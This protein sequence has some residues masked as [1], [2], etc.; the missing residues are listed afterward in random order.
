MAY[1]VR[2]IVHDKLYGS[3]IPDERRPFLDMGHKAQ[4]AVEDFM[5]KHLDPKA[6]TL[7][8]KYRE[9]EVRITFAGLEVVGHVDGLIYLAGNG[10]GNLFEPSYA[11][12]EVKA[13][14]DSN[15]KRLKKAGDM[16]TVYGHYA[17]QAQTYMNADYL[18]PED[19]GTFTLAGPFDYTI[20]VFVNR[21]TS[22]M[23]GGI[24][25][26]HPAWTY[27]EDM[28]LKRDPAWKARLLERLTVAKEALESKTLPEECDAPGY[29]YFCKG[30]GKGTKDTTR[31]GRAVT[32]DFLDDLD[33]EAYRVGYIPL[34]LKNLGDILSE[35]N[36]IF[37]KYKAREITVTG[38]E[39][40]PDYTLTKVRLQEMME[41]VAKWVK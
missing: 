24:P 34:S 7:L 19:G 16:M 36:D 22:E 10:I 9:S 1:C 2:Q 6:G 26:D 28:V 40:E 11:H 5:E 17:G 18:V 32:L 15:F 12:L 14:M 29:C 4:E 37:I 39:D 25:I 21:N 20:Y 8:T 38:L 30:R 31:T 23:M 13:I 41:G 35:A 33:E 27:R 3:Q